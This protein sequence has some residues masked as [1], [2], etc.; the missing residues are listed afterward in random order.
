MA[1]GSTVEGTLSAAEAEGTV[2]INNPRFTQPIVVSTDHLLEAR[3]PSAEP[4]VAADSTDDAGATR[5]AFELNDRSRYVGEVVTWQDDVITLET[6]SVGRVSFGS[7]RVVRIMDVNKMPRPIA[8]L[9]DSRFRYRREAGWE[10]NDQG[11]FGATAQTATVADLDLPDRFRIRIDVTC[12]G[13]PD[14]ELILGDR[15][16][17]GAGQGGG[18]IDRRG[19]SL[20][21]LPTETLVTRIEWF[22]NSVSLVRSN[23]S[24]SD[25]AVFDLTDA[26]DRLTLDLYADQTSGRLL[27]Y[28]EGVK[29]GEVS[30]VD[31]QPVLRRELTLINRGAPVQVTQLELLQWDGRVPESRL[32][33]DRYT[34]L[35]DGSIVEQV[36]RQGDADRIRVGDAWYPIQDLAWV[37]FGGETVAAVGCELVL[38]DGCRLRGEVQGRDTA[39]AIVLRDSTGVRLVVAPP[40]VVRC[41]GRADDDTAPAG[42]A[43]ELRADGIRLWGRLLDGSGTG[44]T[45]G[46]RAALAENDVPITADDGVTILFAS[47]SDVNA[48][49]ESASERDHGLLTLVGG[50]Q[51]PGELISIQ[52]D[53]VRFR[54]VVCNEIRVPLVDVSRVETG[55][56]VKVEPTDLPWLTSLPRRMVDSPPTHLLVSPDGDALRGRLLSLDQQDVRIEVRDRTRRIDRTGVAAVIWLGQAENG[57]EKETPSCRYVITTRDGARLGLQT[58]TFDG[59]VLQ[60]AHQSF[61]DCRIPVDLLQRL[62]FGPRETSRQ[63]RWELVPVKQP[64]TFQ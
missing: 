46:W 22:D 24:V 54:S 13:T 56:A 4:D 42:D 2:Q 28:H 37:E 11:L 40:S 61:G 6:E 58:A 19:G 64:K 25:A 52:S 15:S 59:Y 63:E 53:G 12:Q 35:H 30:L 29:R 23:A 9:A 31:D 10:F 39:G 50:D 5:V 17:G 16:T 20:S 36:A 27:A 60:G 26:I 21:R 62:S 8:S 51:L 44:T 57:A 45:F 49:V 7:E 33:P 43:S 1:D 41:V 18:R 55:P 3:R 32:L 48:D 34:L 38:R 47:P 14:F